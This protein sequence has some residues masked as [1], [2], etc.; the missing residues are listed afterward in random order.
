MSRSELSHFFS[1]N[2]AFIEDVYDR[3]LE[4]PASV[5][6]EWRRYFDTLQ[7]ESA[8]ADGTGNAQA[9]EPATAAKIEQ[10][11][12][13]EANIDVNTDNKKQASVLQ[14]INAHRFRGHQQ[15]DLDPL[16]QYERPKVPE[17]GIPLITISRK[18][19][20]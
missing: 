3:Y 7:Q 17:L 14:L 15:A 16:K 5:T 8:L 2:T 11:P 18:K 20:L 13:L 12:T 1:G 9:E 10:V 19:T 6:V 4:N